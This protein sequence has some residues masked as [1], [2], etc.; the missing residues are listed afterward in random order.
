MRP[1]GFQGMVTRRIG[2]N[3]EVTKCVTQVDKKGADNFCPR[4]FE[5]KLELREDLMLIANH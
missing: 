5:F 4:E 3:S 2:S 1:V